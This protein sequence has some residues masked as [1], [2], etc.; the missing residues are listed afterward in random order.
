[1]VC[2][3][4]PAA[5]GLSDGASWEHHEALARTVVGSGRAWISTVRLDG[6]AALRAC[7]I[8]FR[9]GRTDIDELVRAVNDTRGGP[10]G[11]TAATPRSPLSPAR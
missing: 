10:Y 7:V 9:T 3:A 6:R 1:M 11:R 5:D 8:S 2:F 4:D